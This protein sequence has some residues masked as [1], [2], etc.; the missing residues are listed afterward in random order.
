MELR[1]N[2]KTANCPFCSV[3]YSKKGISA[4]MRRCYL[5]PAQEEDHE[6]ETPAFDQ[7]MPGYVQAYQ[8][9][10]RLNA[11][12]AAQQ[13]PG[14]RAGVSTVG[15]PQNLH[16]SLDDDTKNKEN[17]GPDHSCAFFFCVCLCVWPMLIVAL[18]SY[19][20]LLK[21]ADQ[22]FDQLIWDNLKGGIKAFV[23]ELISE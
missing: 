16:I 3:K 8:Q 18:L 15:H 1:N 22:L 4:H 13:Q 2:A 23:L 7:P 19:S 14:L 21:S 6:S 17:G 12:A 5:A 11:P 20:A 10:A 9:I